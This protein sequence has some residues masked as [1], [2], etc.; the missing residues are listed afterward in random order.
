M[1]GTRAESLPDAQLRTVLF[2][3]I[4]LGLVVGRYLLELDGLKEV[5]A[6]QVAEFMRPCVRTL[7]QAEPHS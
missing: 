6:G 5:P 7:A 1:T 2:G 3:A 4:T